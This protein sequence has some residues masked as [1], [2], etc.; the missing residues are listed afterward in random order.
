MKTFFLIL[1]FCFNT[2]FLA[3]QQYDKISWGL[4]NAMSSATDG[5]TLQI[6]VWLE[7]QF[8][9]TGLGMELDAKK[10][11]LQERAYRVITGLQNHAS[12]S[13]AP[14]LSSLMTLRIPASK[15]SS[16]S[17]SST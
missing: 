16:R 9:I 13:Q 15:I 4:Q 17:G 7:D 2:L 10:A 3:A 5:Q 1:I 12:A 6:E 8:D 11:S 14:F